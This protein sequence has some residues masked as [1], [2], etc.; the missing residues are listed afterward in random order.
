M[1]HVVGALIKWRPLL[2]AKHKPWHRPPELDPNMRITC[3][4]CQAQYELDPTALPPEGRDVQCSLCNHIWF[5]APD[6]AELAF[7]RRAKAAAAP[8][9][10]DI[11]L[12]EMDGALRDLLRAEA[13]HEA[14]A[15]LADAAT[16]SAD[17]GTMAPEITNPESAT[18]DLTPALEWEDATPQDLSQK[19]T[20]RSAAS[21]RSIDD[22]AADTVQTVAVF[23]PDR[24]D[25]LPDA[26]EI[27]KTLRSEADPGRDTAAT[28]PT[29]VLTPSENADILEHTAPR[30]PAK[31]E[32]LGFGL[33]LG[34][35]AALLVVY[36]FGE[37]IGGQFPSLAA[38]LDT[39]V[40]AVDAGRVWL[41]AQLA[42]G[43]ALVFGPAG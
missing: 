25:I 22:V 15:R 5:E 39:Y 2:E 24:R 14:E 19:T 32:G 17:L 41:N 42:F 7:A 20:G 28:A 4:N 35:G 21:P 38:P 10:D 37:A 30:M 29:P 40:T 18:T 26:A 31:G 1:I 27:A 13:Q 16:E 6:P 36:L 12:P 3:Q 33:M 23:T 11:K 8:E 34:I 9:A 43:L